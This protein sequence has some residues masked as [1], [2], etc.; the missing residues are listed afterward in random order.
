MTESERR[1]KFKKWLIE[2]DGK[3]DATA[4][5][6]ASALSYIQADYKERTGESFSFYACTNVGKLKALRTLYGTGGKYENIGKSRS[7]AP[8][9]AIKR[10]IEFVQSE[11]LSLPVPILH[12][13]LENTEIYT[14]TDIKLLKV[15]FIKNI[16]SLFPGY[17]VSKKAKDPSDAAFILENE[18]EKTEY[19]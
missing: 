2:A 5:N 8:I 11:E 4:T 14:L 3:A 12:K 15:L 7:G 10:Y 18:K 1:N 9:N 13:K 16:E 6:Y 19:R 17:S